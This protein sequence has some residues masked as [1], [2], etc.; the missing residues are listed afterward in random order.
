MKIKEA[1][2]R[3][4]NELKGYENE[5][6]FILCEYLQKDRTWLFL[7]ED[8]EFDEKLYFALIE[9][10]KEGEPFEY[11]FNKA[12]FW[13]LEFYIEKGVLIPRYDSEILLSKLIKLCE[14]Q[15]F[16]RILEIGFGSGILSIILAKS[17]NLKIKAC[18][19][20]QKALEIAQKNAKFHGVQALIDFV[21]EDFRKLEG[22]FDLIFSNPPYIKNDYKVDKW[23][24]N[25]PKEALFGGEKG[26]ELLEEIIEFSSNSKAKVLALEFGFDQKEILEKILSKNHFKTEFFKDERGFDRAVLAYKN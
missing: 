17:L 16:N 7:N 14:K 12:F 19:I 13:N 15:N 20:S 18:D 1:L 23:V 2:N 6:I 24:S 3:A 10:F 8:F 11:I 25:E 9:R 21:L 26:Y 5:A 22:E 4:K